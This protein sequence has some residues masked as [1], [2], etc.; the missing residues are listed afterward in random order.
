MRPHSTPSPLPGCPEAKVLCGT[1]ILRLPRAVR[2]QLLSSPWFLASALK[3]LRE[4][5]VRLPGFTVR[6]RAG[7]GSDSHPPSSVPSGLLLITSRNRLLPPSQ[8]SPWELT[9][10]LSFSLEYS[11]PSIQRQLSH[12]LCLFFFFFF[13]FFFFGLHPWHRG[14][15]RL[16]V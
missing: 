11:S 16:W 9:K 2:G 12:P 3:T 13:F 5:Q 1:L 15:S 7:R 8:E 6:V 4:H 14:F 10:S